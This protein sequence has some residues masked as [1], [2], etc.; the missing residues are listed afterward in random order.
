MPVHF[1]TT[2]LLFTDTSVLW[3]VGLVLP[4]YAEI[5]ASLSREPCQLVIITLDSCS[6]T[7][8]VSPCTATPA[9]KC[10]NTFYTC[11]DTAN[12][13]KTTKDYKFTTNKAKSPFEAY[14]YI[15]S[16]SLLP[17]EI[18]R[19]ITVKG[20]VKVDMFEGGKVLLIISPS[21]I[22]RLSLIA[23]IHWPI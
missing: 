11:R 13:A 9:T 23:L 12:Y 8:G 1:K 5:T 18:G 10:Y 22:T 14:P 3:S 16:I 20:R 7:Y 15:D 6:L 21:T 2:P 19:K 17:T 4:T